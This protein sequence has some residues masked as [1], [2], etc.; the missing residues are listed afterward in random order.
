VGVSKK[1]AKEHPMTTYP[2]F[3]KAHISKMPGATPR[4]RMRQVAQ[5]WRDLPASQKTS[6]AR[7]RP[8]GKVMEGKGF[9][10]DFIKG[11]SS[12][13]SFVPGPIGT[14]AKIVDIG[15]KM[16]GGA[17]TSRMSPAQIRTIAKQLH[18]GQLFATKQ[19]AFEEGK[20]LA[21]QLVTR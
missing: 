20:R 15:T 6:S 8:A 12:I 18:G 10:T 3:V 2:A 21:E 9:L 1:K 17:V 7:P 5:K 19:A 13:L 14:V 4:E 11:A 16:F